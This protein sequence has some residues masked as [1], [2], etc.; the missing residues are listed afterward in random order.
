VEA[1]FDLSYPGS[2]LDLHI[3]DQM[4]N[5]VGMNYDTMQLDFDIPGAT[6]S[7]TLPNPEWIKLPVTGGR[8]FRVAVVG[9][10]VFGSESFTVTLTEYPN[11]RS[12]SLV[13]DS[14]HKDVA[15]GEETMFKITLQNRGNVPDTYHLALTGLDETWFSLSQSL[16]SLDPGS[17]TAATLT[18]HPQS[19]GT[20]S[21]FVIAE[22][23]DNSAISD[24]VEA[25]LD[26]V[27]LDV[28]PPTTTLT[29]GQPK[30]IS[31]T[32]YVTPDTPLILEATDTGS[33]VYSIAY[34]INSTTYNSGWQTYTTPFKLTSL[35]D[36]AYTIEYNS[37]DNVQNTETTH[38]TSV[39]LF[40]WNYVYQD[41][42]GRGT[43][44]KINL[45]HKFFQFI[46]PSKDYGIR[47]A[48]CMQQCGRAIIINHCDKQLRLITASVDTKI[49][50]CYAMAWDLQ[51]RK[52]HLL[53]D[54]AGIE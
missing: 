3:Y 25:S 46:A 52:C 33:G 28:T 53:I 51:T 48:T 13:L 43:T 21:F 6:Y 34:R 54:K 29:I 17:M 27:I 16:F 11:Y 23:A 10:A 26:V 47:K 49:D 8:V 36:G 22:C 35:T 4:G 45:A 32:T 15:Y 14:T 20:Y 38:A 40:H 1:E 42:Y 2:D 44:L 19:V 5:H 39:T 41:T 50:F 37:T 7:G 12:P 18:I 31:D 9:V 24:Q 30:Y